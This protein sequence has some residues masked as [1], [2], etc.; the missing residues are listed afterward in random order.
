MSCAGLGL[1]HPWQ[2]AGPPE[3]PQDMG[4]ERA[5]WLSA[6]ADMCWA[7][8]GQGAGRQGTSPGTRLLCC[9]SALPQPQA[10]LITLNGLVPGTTCR[11][12]LALCSVSSSPVSTT[13]VAA[14]LVSHSH[15]PVAVGSVD[16]L[17]EGRG[18]CISGVV[19]A[20]IGFALGVLH[21]G[22]VRGAVSYTTLSAAC[23]CLWGV[24]VRCPRACAQAT[25]TWSCCIML[26]EGEHV[27]SCIM[28]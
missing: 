24:T 16:G 7:T 22:W 21:R 14:G 11:V 27:G 28:R 1:G 10:A 5:V 17:V 13:P 4:R 23:L 19:V 18:G 12:S 8:A 9:L 26:Q 3:A 20:S 2:G 25:Q 15:L 6:A